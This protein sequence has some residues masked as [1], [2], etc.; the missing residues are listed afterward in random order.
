M[1]ASFAMILSPRL[2]DAGLSVTSFERRSSVCTILPQRCH[3]RMSLRTQPAMRQ[4]TTRLESLR[5]TVLMP[6]WHWHGVLEILAR[7]HLPVSTEALSVAVLCLAFAG[8]SVFVLAKLGHF[9]RQR[10]RCQLCRGPPDAAAAGVAAAR[11]N[12]E[13]KEKERTDANNYLAVRIKHV[14]VVIQ[15]LTGVGM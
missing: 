15:R 11:D 13:R 4:P 7:C 12:P 2:S 9:P 3:K 1:H 10:D 14:L 5:I 8:D 6:P